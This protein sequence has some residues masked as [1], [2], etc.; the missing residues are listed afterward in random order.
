[1]EISQLLTHLAEH[2]ASKKHS[3]SNG[4]RPNNDGTMG[5]KLHWLPSNSMV[6]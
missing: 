4:T 2:M 5:V 6:R 1:M 3:L